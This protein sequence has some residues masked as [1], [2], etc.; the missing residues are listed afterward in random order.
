MT[1]TLA[2]SIRRWY[3]DRY[4]TARRMAV[5]DSV[6]SQYPIYLLLDKAADD[7]TAPIVYATAAGW[8]RLYP[9]AFLLEVIRP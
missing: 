4:R 9:A 3:P 8:K 1:T 6:V 7:P 5:R 2:D